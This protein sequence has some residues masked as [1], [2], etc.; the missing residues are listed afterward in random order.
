MKNK[1]KNSNTQYRYTEYPNIHEH[2]VTTFNSIAFHHVASFRVSQFK[3]VFEI[4]K[5]GV[6][7]LMEIL[8]KCLFQSIKRGRQYFKKLITR[9]MLF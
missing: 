7:K 6:T 2:Q 3:L 8:K 5:C 9:A 4:P 1:L